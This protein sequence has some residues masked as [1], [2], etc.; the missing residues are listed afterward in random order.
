MKDVSAHFSVDHHRVYTAG[1]SGGARMATALALSGLVKG[2]IACSAGFPEPDRVPA[3]I[4]F[5]FF[6]TAGTEDF[7]YREMRKLDQVLGERGMVHRLVVFDGGHEWASAALGQKLGDAAMESR[8]GQRKLGSDLR[9]ES[10]STEDS[11]ER[12][13]VRRAIA[14]YR[15]MTR[16]RVRE[17]FDQREYGQASAML[18]LSAFLQP[19]QREV[20][21]D[22]ARACAFDGDKKEALA[23]LNR[24]LDAGFRNAPRTEAEPAF[25][26]LR[27]DPSGG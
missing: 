3:K 7:N 26:K 20:F 6:G 12:R 25:A 23:A 24:A 27:G 9:R 18:E 16:Q 17:L 11:P 8:G 15:S 2:V 13:M 19:G 21:F 14:A 5:G 22:L 10:E 4:A 1:V